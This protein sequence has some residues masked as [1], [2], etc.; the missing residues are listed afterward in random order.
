MD[1]VMGLHHHMSTRLEQNHYIT[2]KKQP[3]VNQ[4]GHG[5]RS[6]YIIPCAAFSLQLDEVL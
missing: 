6:L 4:L 3:I 2:H 1:S 5:G